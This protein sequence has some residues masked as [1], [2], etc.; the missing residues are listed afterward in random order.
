MDI[1]VQLYGIIDRG[2]AHLYFPYPLDFQSYNGKVQA[3]WVRPE[4]F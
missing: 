3:S 2:L 4:V 1:E